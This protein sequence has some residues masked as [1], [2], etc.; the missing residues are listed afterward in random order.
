MVFLLPREWNE[1]IPRQVFTKTVSGKTN[2][3]F[4]MSKSRIS[5][6]GIKIF[7]FPN[8]RFFLLKWD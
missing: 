5:D 6:L 7:V 2:R 3:V 4:F 8:S 1:T